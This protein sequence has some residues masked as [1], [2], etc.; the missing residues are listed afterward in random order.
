MENWQKKKIT[1][2]AA[3]MSLVLVYLFAGNMISIFSLFVPYRDILRIVLCV[4]GL[5]VMFL[6]LFNYRFSK[7]NV[8]LVMALMLLV[9]LPTTVLF[10]FQTTSIQ[11]AVLQ[12]A[13][14]VLWIAVFVLCY[15]M[16]IRY[17]DIV[18]KSSIF[19]LWIPVF[20]VLFLQ[21]KKFSAG[22]GIPLISTAY[23]AL[24]LLPFALIIKR[25][26]LKWG[27]VAIVFSS[28]MLSMKRGGFI[29]FVGAIAIYLLVDMQVSGR[30]NI[31]KHLKKLVLLMLI[32]VAL[33]LFFQYYTANHELG[34]VDRLNSIQEDGGSGRTEIWA[35]V[36]EGIKASDPGSIVFGHGFNTVYHTLNLGVSAHND[37]LEVLY[38]YGVLGLLLYAVIICKVIS[39]FFVLMREGSE[40]AAPYAASL[41]L[42]IVLS[43]VAHL[44]IFPTHF[45][46]LCAFWG[47]VIGG[48]DKG[49][50]IIRK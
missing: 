49:R 43:V 34:I 9:I 8:L 36:W 24:F 19:C 42:F 38:D 1:H 20:S 45:L 11:F 33:V 47:F 3:L 41:V 23:Y 30:G 22:R 31:K 26:W 6:I 48:H 16:A 10:Y 7:K 29:A 27:L 44:V 37:L 2:C 21:V 32:G 28:V 50:R 39:Y 5:F 46:Y 17:P 13:D 18:K 15:W 14:S 25:A 4:V 12:C 40:L 35:A